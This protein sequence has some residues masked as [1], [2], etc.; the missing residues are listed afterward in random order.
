MQQIH[1]KKF[2]TIYNNEVGLTKILNI[3]GNIVQ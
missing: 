3:A 2:L 1:M